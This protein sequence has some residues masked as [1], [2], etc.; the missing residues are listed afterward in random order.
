MATYTGTYGNSITV[1]LNN[2]FGAGGTVQSYRTGQVTVD[3]ATI[4]ERSIH[5]ISADVT[6]RAIDITPFGSGLSNTT[7]LQLITNQKIA[8]RIGDIGN[9]PISAVRYLMLAAQVSGL[10]ITTGSLATTVMFTLFG[11]SNA[12]FTMTDPLPA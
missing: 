6:D 4:L 7:M 10:F 8:V 1:E 3:S 11:G 2:N 9:T 12:T 5:E